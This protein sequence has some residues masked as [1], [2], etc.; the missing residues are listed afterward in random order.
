MIIVSY[1]P[2]RGFRKGSKGSHILEISQFLEMNSPI[3][4]NKYPILETIFKSL[5]DFLLYF[6]VGLRTLSYF[7]FLSRN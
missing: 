3:S 5:G 1:L 6:V 7:N 4:R 2:V